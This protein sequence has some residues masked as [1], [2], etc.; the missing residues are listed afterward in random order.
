M[1]ILCEHLPLCW[2]EHFSVFQSQN[3][4]SRVSIFP[5]KFS[6][7][8]LPI[9]PLCVHCYVSQ[10]FLSQRK[11]PPDCGLWPHQLP[12]K[13]PP[14]VGGVSTQ[15]C[16]LQKFIR[17]TKYDVEIVAKNDLIESNDRIWEPWVW[18]NWEVLRSVKWLSNR[19]VEKL[20]AKLTFIPLSNKIQFNFSRCHLHYLN[21]THD[22][23]SGQRHK[24]SKLSGRLN[25]TYKNFPD[26]L[27]KLFSRCNKNM[28]KV[29]K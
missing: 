19:A 8:S 26:G 29:R 18:K 12:L 14:W 25:F 9:S 21:T 16:S 24:T 11:L 27:R 2:S 6:P 22:H 7:Q 23:W 28:P 5:L 17:P 1:R 15:K 20:K 3:C 13:F 4:S 10:H